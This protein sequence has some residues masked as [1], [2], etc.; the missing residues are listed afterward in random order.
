MQK[1]SVHHARD[2]KCSAGGL[3]PIAVACLS[4]AGDLEPM[5]N[6]PCKS[7]SRIY[8][9]KAQR[10]VVK[11]RNLHWQSEESVSEAEES[12][13]EPGTDTRADSLEENSSHP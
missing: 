7:V 2:P 6:V 8:T 3:D 11:T 10:P 9:G 4:P 12:E 5:D 1:R 13:L